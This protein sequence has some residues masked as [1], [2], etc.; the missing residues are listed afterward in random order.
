MPPSPN[1]SNSEAY[2]TEWLTSLLTERLGL[3]RPGGVAV[4][5]DDPLRSLGLD[6]LSMLELLSVLEQELGEDGFPD[7]LDLRE[8]TVAD[9]IHYCQVR[10]HTQVK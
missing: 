1:Q 4:T 5:S 3:S 2:T 7:Q 6:S 8:A 10:S 9:V